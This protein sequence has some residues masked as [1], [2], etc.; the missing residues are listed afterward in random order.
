IVLAALLF[1]PF[2]ARSH[3]DDGQA[4]AGGAA[5]LDIPFAGPGQLAAIWTVGPDRPDTE[6]VLLLTRGGHTRRIDVEGPRQVRWR[7]PTELLLEQRIDAKG[8]ARDRI[9][10][11]D[12]SGSIIEVLSDGEGLG[13]CEPSPDGRWAALL[14]SSPSTP[15][16]YE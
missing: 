5:P 9:V 12:R 14:R 13:Y 8:A 4:A 1:G 7:S 6:K 15:T 3:S 10:R 16:G 2:D 11:M